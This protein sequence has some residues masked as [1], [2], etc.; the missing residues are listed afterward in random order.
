MAR[1][2]PDTVAC[3]DPEYQLFRRPEATHLVIRGSC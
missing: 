1:P 3:V 2:D